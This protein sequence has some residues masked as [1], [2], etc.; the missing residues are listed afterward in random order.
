MRTA[1]KSGSINLGSF[2]FSKGIGIILVILTHTFAHINLEQSTSLC[3]IKMLVDCTKAGLM[4]MFFMISGFW[5]IKRTPGKMLKK[6]FPELIIPYL[7]VMAAYAV[8]FP[9]TYYH[10]AYGG[11]WRP[12]I[13]RTLQYIVAFVLGIGAS[14]TVVFGYETAWCTA[15]W[16]FLALFVALNVLNLILQI[17]NPAAQIVCVILCPILGAVLF[18]LNFFF[19][20][21]P[22]GLMAVGYCYVGYALKKYRLFGQLQSCKRIYLIL[23]PVFLAELIW[24]YF[25]LRQGQF[26]NV[27]LDYFG[28]GCSGILLML[29]GIHLGKPEWKGLNRIKQF[30]LY[31]HWIFTIHAVEMEALPWWHWEKQWTQNPWAA[32]ILELAIKSLIFFIVCTLLKANKKRQYSRKMAKEKHK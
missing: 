17:K 5:L 3:L 31:T 16:F 6:T 4:P 22:Q 13:A 12:T 11:Q 24:G 15:A 9:L 26:R 29:L 2:A 25:D 10:A 27:F 14:G 20:C 19:Y 30:G 28:A 32:L 8:I 7:W 18:H 1:S 23:V 21:I